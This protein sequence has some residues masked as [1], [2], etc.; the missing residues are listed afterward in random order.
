MSISLTPCDDGVC[1]CRG[2]P[3]DPL[4]GVVF[5]ILEL[6]FSFADFEIFAVA[7]VPLGRVLAELDVEEV[8]DDFLMTAMLFC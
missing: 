2:F 7:A 8:E 4:P 6:E 5:F 1:A 3:A